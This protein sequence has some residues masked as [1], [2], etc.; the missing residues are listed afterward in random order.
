[1]FNNMQILNHKRFFLICFSLKRLFKE[2]M[3]I[4]CLKLNKIRSSILII[5]SL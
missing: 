5:S 2:K 1:M 4:K 3:N